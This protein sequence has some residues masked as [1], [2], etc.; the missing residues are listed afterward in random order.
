M[1]QVDILN[2]KF[3]K[4]E[5]EDKIEV[6][7]TDAVMIGKAIRTDI[8]QIVVTEDSIDKMEVGLGMNKITGEEISVET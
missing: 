7:M 3:T 8:G 6:I 2:H 4:V 5:A 1:E